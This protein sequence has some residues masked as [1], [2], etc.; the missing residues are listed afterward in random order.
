VRKT[1]RNRDVVTLFARCSPLWF[2]RRKSI[3]KASWSSK[4]F[5]KL[6]DQP[7][8]R[9]I[10]FLLLVISFSYLGFPLLCAG[11]VWWV[12]QEPTMSRWDR[13]RAAL[14]IALFGFTWLV[15]V[16]EPSG[17]SIIK[18]RAAKTSA[19][20]WQEICCARLLDR[21]LVWYD[22]GLAY[23]VDDRRE[24]RPSLKRRFGVVLGTSVLLG[25]LL[26]LLVAIV[27]SLLSGRVPWPASLDG[28]Y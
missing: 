17:Y 23:R 25:P 5:S 28:D 6:L 9:L 21:L 14:G 8:G 13:A 10:V 1:Y 27:R 16:T 2:P 26:G 4:G 24:K 11:L 12:L 3:L 18:E 19:A 22:F 7:E 20:L 15:L